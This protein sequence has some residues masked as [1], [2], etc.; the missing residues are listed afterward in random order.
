MDLSPNDI[1]N[2][3]FSS[4]MRGYEKNAVNSFLEQVAN[5]IESLKQDNLKASVEIDSLKSQLA[6][7]RKFED[8]I[9]N[10]AIDARHNADMTV[11]NA[12]KEAELIMSKARAEAEEIIR[13]RSDQ[14]T[15]IERRIAKIKLTERSY[16]SRLK[17]TIESH[18]EIVNEIESDGELSGRL[19]GIQVTDSSEVD[20]SHNEH[21]G[22]PGQKNE[23][24]ETTPESSPVLADSVTE[25][26][27]DSFPTVAAEPEPS[28]PTE[29]VQESVDPNLAA[30]MQ[31]SRN[32]STPT[33]APEPP[34]PTLDGPAPGQWI[35]T[36]RKAKDVPDGFI[37]NADDHGK[38]KSATDKV[39]I[40]ETPPVDVNVSGTG[41]TPVPTPPVK[42]LNDELDSIAAKFDEEMDKADHS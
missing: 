23:T 3:E 18:L 22:A 32:E 9:K 34:K 12:K 36:T 17:T 30:A 1:R 13:S 24:V 7:L 42:N 8:T 35:E 10:A 4:Q 21:A 28:V 27:D 39:K 20:D 14:V 38:D 6:G 37:T 5:S 29:T 11:A 40:V 16:L 33:P 41:H 15:E 25:S 19:E 2:Y 26:S 31:G